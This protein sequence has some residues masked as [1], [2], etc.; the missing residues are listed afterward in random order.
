MS[1]ERDVGKL[2]LGI[3]ARLGET[4]KAINDLQS[5]IFEFSNNTSDGLK[6]VENNWQ[7]TMKGFLS[8][9]AV[10]QLF[11][12]LK[13]LVTECVYA[14]DQETTSIA[15]LRLEVGKSADNLVEFAKQQQAVTRY[16]RD[17]IVAV[18]L[19]L[20]QYVKSEEQI[21]RL[22]P[23]IENFATA[24]G[25]D[26]QTAAMLF[27]RSMMSNT[28]SLGRMHLGITG[29]ANSQERINSILEKS[30][31]LWGGQAEAVAKLG[32]GPLVVL[33]NQLDDM[34]SS[35]GEKFL[36]YIVDFVQWFKEKGVPIIKELMDHLDVIVPLIKNAGEAFITY[37]A[38]K[39]LLDISSGF[40]GLAGSIRNFDASLKLMNTNV[41]ILALS[42]IYGWVNLLIDRMEKLNSLRNNLDWTKNKE[43]LAQ[44]RALRVEYDEM[45]AMTTVDAGSQGMTPQKISDARK[46]MAAIN[47]QVENISGFTFEN[48]G[49]MYT[50]GTLTNL[51]NQAPSPKTGG[52][53][54]GG[55]DLEGGGNKKDMTSLVSQ[56]KA[57]EK[58]TE[59]DAAMDIKA[60]MEKE[61][62]FK[63]SVLKLKIDAMNEETRL[64]KE[65][66][67]IIADIRKKDLEDQRKKMEEERQI[68]VMRLQAAEELTGGLRA[69]F[70]N[71]YDYTGRK[72]KQLFELSKAAAIAEAFIQMEMA[73]ERI[74]GQW[75]AYPVVAAL[76]EAVAMGNMMLT[77]ARIQTTTMKAETGGLLLK[78]KSH[79]QGGI[80]VEAEGGEY[81]HRKSTVDYYGSSVMEAINQRAIPRSV[82]SNYS[83]PVNTVGGMA[84]TGGK[85][86]GNMTPVNNTIVN[87]LDESVLDR[88]LASARG[89][90]AIVN[91]ISDRSYE[92]GRL[93]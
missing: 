73:T 32:L 66:S 90:D 38:A 72:N 85:V 91:V 62:E 22:I 64:E 15:R 21:K 1:E 80:I 34:K 79:S 52:T 89:K 76:L 6:K 81:F 10:M 27:V 61:A 16:S 60:R 86:A 3:E 44:V 9:E 35:I 59:E 47:K 55:L 8:A 93:L 5:K 29:T 24:T 58:K 13:G 12:K 63:N 74:W 69:F 40:I 11:Y 14:F 39:K 2:I 84:A 54:T 75:G 82:L 67:K 42:A 71:L 49:S 30:N 57:I 68:Q 20:G 83:S 28:D 92:I 17:Q 37:L 7:S 53:P 65:K 41:M 33:K 50:V 18:E 51:M 77:V 88:Y 45:L 23:A 46:R 25:R 43:T 4:N 19:T 87:V 48:T 78:G 31:Q 70:D 56:W 36:P 26:V